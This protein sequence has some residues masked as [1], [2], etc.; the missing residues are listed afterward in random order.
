MTPEQAEAR[1]ER[2]AI[3][4]VEGMSEDDAQKYC[5]SDPAQYGIRD[6]SEKQEVM[7]EYTRSMQR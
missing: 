4:T 7:F 5:D 1:E 2:I 6:Y 3:M